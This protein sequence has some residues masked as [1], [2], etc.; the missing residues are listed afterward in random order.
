MPP[1]VVFD[2]KNI[3]LEWAEGT[4]Y[5]ISDSGWNYLIDDLLSIS[6]FYTCSQLILL[7]DGHSS[8]HNLE[9]VTFARKNETNIFTLVPHTTHEMQPLDTAVFSSLQ[10]NWQNMCH[11]YIQARPGMVM[12]KYGS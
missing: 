5:D 12:T 2:A 7:L 4:T 8:Q 6:W 1:F 9:A 10:I 11:D 3:N